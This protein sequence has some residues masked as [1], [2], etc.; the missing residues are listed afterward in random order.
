MILQNA[1]PYCFQGLFILLILAHFLYLAPFVE[2]CSEE[3]ASVPRALSASAFIWTYLSDVYLWQ[4]WL[5][6]DWSLWGILSMAATNLGLSV[7]GYLLAKPQNPESERIAKAVLF[8]A[9]INILFQVV[10]AIC[11]FILQARSYE[12]FVK[13]TAVRPWWKWRSSQIPAQDAACNQPLSRSSS[14]LPLDGIYQMHEYFRKADR[15]K[16]SHVFA[17]VRRLTGKKKKKKKKTQA[18]RRS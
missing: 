5:R 4:Y 3:L 6:P 14:V 18:L 2:L 11:L 16:L 9:G 7:V 12:P 1:H 17:P 10:F 8:T 13:N 15:R